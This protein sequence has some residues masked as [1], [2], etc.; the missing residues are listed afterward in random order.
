MSQPIIPPDAAMTSFIAV[1]D[2]ERARHFYSDV[3][4]LELIGDNAPFA[5]VYRSGGR[6]LRVSIVGTLAPQPFTVVGWEVTDI[7]AKVHALMEKGIAFHRYDGMGQDE[8]GLWQPP[9]ATGYVAWFSDPDG[10][11]LSLSGS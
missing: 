4:G 6:T 5:L 7:R 3:L 10:N 9:G 11:V 8:L 2:P 1:T